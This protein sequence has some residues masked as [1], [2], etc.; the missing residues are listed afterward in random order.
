MRFHRVAFIYNP[1]SG[2]GK[3]DTQVREIREI[4]A[5]NAGDVRLM[6]THGPHH[7]SELARKAAS[8]GY[9]LVAAL[10]GDGT[11]NEI[12]QGLA[13]TV[14][15]ALLVL[16]GGTANVLVKEVGLPMDPSAAA[17]LLPSLKERT[18]QLGMVESAERG[19]RY[20][21][22]MFGAGFDAAVAARTPPALKRRLGV[23]AFWLSGAQQAVRGLPRLRIAEWS[24]PGGGRPC[25]LVVVSKSRR[26]GGGLVCT[27]SANLLSSQ[28]EVAHFTGRSRT[29]YCGYLLASIC[30]LTARW[31]G[32]HHTPATHLTLEACEGELVQF[33]VDGEVAGTLPAR[34]SVS[35][36]SVTLLLPPAYQPA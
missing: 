20:F 10:G 7:S 25:S 18:I 31:P 3:S 29:Q 16:P 35:S 26:Y 27:P 14:R 32:I 34:V 23:A 19:T 6:P 8:D 28:F 15:P 1:V 4:L 11:A 5:A 9:D 17:A 13:G 24:G 22:L 36:S 21:L 33:Q 12:V 2:G 30:D